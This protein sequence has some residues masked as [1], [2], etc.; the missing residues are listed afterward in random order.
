[1]LNILPVVG[2]GDNRIST[3]AWSINSFTERTG[4]VGLITSTF[5]VEPDMITGLKSRAKS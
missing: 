1:M 2:L 3:L 4:S 5:E